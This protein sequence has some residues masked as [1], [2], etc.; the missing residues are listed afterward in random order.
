MLKLISLVGLWCIGSMLAANAAPVPT[1]AEWEAVA[2]AAKAEGKVVV[3]AS[4]FGNATYKAITK[5]F[6]AKYGVTVETLDIRASE[7]YERVRVEQSSGRFIGDIVMEPRSVITVIERGG[8]MQPYLGVPNIVNQ[9]AGI[10]SD[11]LRV[12]VYSQLY[13]ILVNAAVGAADEPKTWHDLLDPKWKG[14]IILDDPRAIGNGFSLFNATYKGLGA[15]FQEKLSQQSPVISRQVRGDERRIAQGEYPLYAPMN[16]SFFVEMKG[17][18]V[19]FVFPTEGSPN[20]D[21]TVVTLKGAPH[22]NAARLFINYLLD[23]ESQKSYGNA[24]L[25]PSVKGVADHLDANLRRMND[26]KL[27]PQVDVDEMNEIMAKAKELYK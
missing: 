20:A 10:G 13:G 8:L 6:E 12:P 23:A 11:D 3:Y 19:R 15:E 4:T 5:A 1:P 14:K 22:M 24:G 21:T 27:L 18:P 7:V 16:F 26:V 9:R 17:L 25:L 2:R